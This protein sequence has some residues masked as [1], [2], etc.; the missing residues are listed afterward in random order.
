MHVRRLL[1]SASLLL[2]GAF[3]TLLSAG[4]PLGGLAVAVTPDGSRLAVG[5]DSRTLYVVDAT[6]LAVTQRIWTGTSMVRLCFNK[7]GSRLWVEDTSGVARIYETEKFTQL[8]EIPKAS[9]LSPAR[10]ADVVVALDPNHKGHIL[11]AYSMTDWSEKGSVTFP[12]GLKV[13]S[14]GVDATGTK[15]A[16]ITRDS[17]DPEE[18][19]ESQSKAPK[20]LKGTAKDTWVQ[21][22]DGK[23]SLLRIYDLPAFTQVSE[24]KTWFK[25]QEGS[26]VFFG[27]G[28][29]HAINYSNDNA[30]FDADGEAEMFELAH[31]FNYGVGVSE[32]QS[33]VLGGSLA[34]G[35]RSTVADLKGTKFRA[36]KLPGWPEYFKSF[37][38]TMEGVG[39]G[40]TSGYRLTR[41]LADGTIEK[42]VPIY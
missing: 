42:S 11:R 23:T 4:T 14:F 6:S 34:S 26:L 36:D 3:A 5:G 30:R 2:T 41:I 33:V 29:V 31:G 18:P 28:K 35:S 16:M 22:H 38:F 12:K 17:K 9:H 8:H 27:A 15:L 25:T 37:A 21:K 1:T 20:E 39:Y 7:D 19:R 10:Q 32:D 13:G 24:K 40:T